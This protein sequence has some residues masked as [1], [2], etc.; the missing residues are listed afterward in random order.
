MLDVPIALHI[1]DGFLSGGVALACALLLTWTERRW[2]EVQ[3]AIIG[4]IFV[5]AAS[6]AVLLLA[7]NP[8][9][10]DDE[11][12]RQ[13]G[14]EHSHVE[15]VGAERRDA[16]VCEGEGLHGDHDVHHE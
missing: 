5:V 8:H 2:P 6:A 16:A 4:V 11:E 7:G 15:D 10:G 13:E 3:E 9:G 1:P 12:A 14:A